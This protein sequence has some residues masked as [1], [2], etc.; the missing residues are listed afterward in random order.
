MPTA[1]PLLALLVLL[2]PVTAA[3]AAGPLPGPVAFL[4]GSWRMALTRLVTARRSMRR[5][6][7]G[8]AR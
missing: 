1:R 2:A 4:F 8:R 3:T 6:G 7:W 5:S